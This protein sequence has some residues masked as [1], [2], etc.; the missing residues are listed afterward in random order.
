MKENNFRDYTDYIKI[1]MIFWLTNI[2][3][4]DTTS[5]KYRVVL[6]YFE[7]NG[8]QKYPVLIVSRR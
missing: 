4:I 2:K 8:E 3:R 5:H 6:H 1:N 7:E